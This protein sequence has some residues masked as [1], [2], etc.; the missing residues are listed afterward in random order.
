MKNKN[1]YFRF[2]KLISKNSFFAQNFIIILLVVTLS[3]G[4]LGYLVYHLAQKQVENEIIELNQSALT[5]SRDV[6]DTLF[7][8]LKKLSAQLQF[9]KSMHYYL[10]ISSENHIKNKEVRENIGDLQK[11]F[12]LI[13]DYIDSIYI[14][15]NNKEQIMTT[16]GDI[17]LKAMKDISWYE[18]YLNN[19]DNDELASGWF[20][21][22]KMDR[23][24]LLDPYVISFIN[25]ARYNF[26]AKSQ[27]CIV[28]NTD[29]K[30]IVKI[31]GREYKDKKGA[32]H[33]VDLEGN[34]FFSNDPT[35]ISKNIK[36]YKYYDEKMLKN[37]TFAHIIR[38]KND[39]AIVSSIKSAKNDWIY[40]NYES[41]DLYKSRVSNLT[42][43]TLVII[44]MGILVT[45][46]I[47]VLTSVYI[48]KPIN[49][50]IKVI[51]ENTEIDITHKNSASGYREFNEIIY[52]INSVLQSFDTNR[53]MK[54]KLEK[55]LLK[56]K[57]SQTLALQAQIN[58]HFMCNTL[59]TIRFLS[60]KE[61]GGET[62]VSDMLLYLSVMFRLS[63]ESKEFIISIQDE[64][65]YCTM[66]IKIM[67]VRYYDKVD[68]TWDIDEQL[69]SNKIVKLCLQP[70]IENAIYHG[71]KPLERKGH[72]YITGRK[73]NENIKMS[74]ADDGVG[75]K[76]HE[77]EQLNES[78][79]RAVLFYDDHVGL[80][81]V[82]QRIRLIYGEDYGLFV[83]RAI[84]GGLQVDILL[85]YI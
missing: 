21:Y 67:K 11:L 7:I 3:M 14:Y 66:Y 41:I 47:T 45:L 1:P 78:L 61:A 12:T 23:G 35:H 4:I 33:I 58:P 50:I 70:I 49:R 39:E 75:L 19:K 8:E 69:L 65:D 30:E 24:P 54:E 44:V 5:N 9:E 22:R 26:S 16:R 55:N 25:P 77:I 27:G 36:D 38:E 68:V 13:Y 60:M 31:I 80:R 42:D 29:V 79:K 53:A 57:Q 63:M 73:V 76:D 37:K 52:I 72:I 81:N 64:I 83:K 43:F 71:I 56:I 74:I 6:V 62:N 51:E 48:Y 59:E 17:S 15:S 40:I 2:V 10:N 82:N 20:N 46:T 32:F 18:D 28:I 84:E 34:I 85:K